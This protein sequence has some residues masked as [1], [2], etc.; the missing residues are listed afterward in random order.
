MPL[1]LIA[2]NGR[3][4]LLAR[5]AP[6]KAGI[7]SVAIGIQEEAAP[8]IEPL[9]ARCYWISLG[10]LSKLIEICHRE[11]ITQ[12]MMCG[13]VKHASIF[14]AIVPDW[15]LV[16]LL[17]SLETKNTEGLIGG[18]A[19]VLAEEG[20]ELAD[21][22]LLLKN[23]LAREGI[24]SRRKPSGDEMRDLD[25]GRKIAA[26][27]A[28]LDIGQSVAIAERPVSRSRR[29]REPTPCCAAPGRLPP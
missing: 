2:G 1:G 23:L 10:A 16:K 25:Y 18:V 11:K 21:S 3:F 22:T 19:R 5:D 8:E 7:E 27:L 17:A 14:S 15:R 6:R 24:L 26:A 12:V 29:W 20:I 9:A 4:P 28:S 13:Q